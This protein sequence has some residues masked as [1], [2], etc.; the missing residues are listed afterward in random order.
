M[1]SSLA[2]WFHLITSP[3]EYGEEAAFALG[4]LRDRVDG[5]VA[6]LLEL[7]CGGGNMASHLK[8]HVRLTLT[9]L[10]REMLEVSR[11]HNPDLD[12]LQ[13]DMRSLRL[14]REFDA[15][16]VHDAVMYLLDEESLRA[17]META[18]VHLRPGGAAIF[19]PDF[20]RET[21]RPET[22]HGGNDR[23][24]RSLRYLEWAWDPDP[25][26]TT[27]V[28]DYAYLLREGLGPARVVHDRHVVGLFARADW[29]RLLADVG[30]EP[31]CVLDPG[32]R[33]VFV[34]VRRA[35]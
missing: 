35:E 28:V 29:L 15:V 1:Y 31:H 6:E 18:F 2:D 11:T 9:D 21:F 5:P 33:D 8:R 10:S 13:G 16:L 14:D 27:V 26:D 19:A 22:G 32:R 3:E 34:G 20:V 4:A 7:G 12:H 25:E 30:F 17:A 24:G 23:D